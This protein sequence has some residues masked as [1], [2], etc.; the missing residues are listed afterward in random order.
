[1]LQHRIFL[2]KSAFCPE[3]AEQQ[4]GAAPGQGS[5]QEGSPGSPPAARGAVQEECCLS[6][7]KHQREGSRRPLLPPCLINPRKRLRTAAPS[8]SDCAVNGDEPISDSE[9]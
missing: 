6:D 4:Q 9:I 2:L 1:L 8:A 7:G 3:D 5:Q